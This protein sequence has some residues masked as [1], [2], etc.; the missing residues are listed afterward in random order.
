MLLLERIYNLSDVR[1]SVEAGDRLSFRRFLAMPAGESAPDDTTLVKFRARMRRKGLL[2]ETHAEFNRQLAAGGLFVKPG[3]IRVVDATVIRAATR[4]ARA[5]RSH[6]GSTPTRPS[7]VRRGSFN[8]ATR[9]MR[10]STPAP[11]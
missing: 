10:E 11:A 6:R 1:V 3:A 8:S 2:E 5:P 4:R 7:A 9:C